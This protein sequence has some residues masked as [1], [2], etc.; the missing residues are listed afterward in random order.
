MPPHLSLLIAVA[1]CAAATAL[2]APSQPLRVCN[3]GGEGCCSCGAG[4]ATLAALQF[5]TPLDGP[6]AVGSSCLARCD[7][8]VAVKRP[9]GEVVVD[10]NGPKA[11]ADLLRGMGYTIDRRLTYAY[12]AASRADELVEESRDREALNAYKRAFSLAIAAG[13]GISWGSP[14]GVERFDDDTRFVLEPGT[15]YVKGQPRGSGGSARSVRAAKAATP[16]QLRWLARTMTSRSRVYSRIANPTASAPVATRRKATRRAI[17]D[18]KYAVALA[19]R[20][21]QM[22]EGAGAEAGLLSDEDAAMATA[23]AVANVGGVAVEDAEGP[24]AQPPAD[25]AVGFGVDPVLTE[26]WER[27]AESY[28]GSRDIEGAITAYEALLRLEPPNAPGLAPPVAAKRGVQELVLLSHRRGIEDTQSLTEG[29][30]RAGESTRSSMTARAISDVEALRKTVERDLD[31]LEA[32]ARRVVNA[33]GSAVR[34]ADA[35]RPPGSAAA[36]PGGGG[37]LERQLA[38]RTLEDLQVVRKIARSDINRL[39]LTLLRGDPL[40]ALFRDVRDGK[41]VWRP[42]SWLRSRGWQ[43]ARGA[44]RLRKARGLDVKEGL[45]DVPAESEIGMQLREQFERGVL[46]QDPLLIQVLLEQ[47]K[48]DPQLVSR[49]V[50][51]AKDRRTGQEIDER[52]R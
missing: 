44:Q 27:L 36:A 5:L 30:Q 20:S 22:E 12:A 16:T 23:A 49:L 19:E 7:R 11:C 13:L 50:A 8:G 26:A 31:T 32:N 46:P 29:L 40:L 34:P 35:E 9:S 42:L 6:Q 41:V 15:R 17:E 4:D 45:R 3:V 37:F 43:G 51:E 14:P 1:C 33:T 47:A 39:E 28:E 48:T 38:M 25:G 24:V 18:A 10:V 52:A 21:L 2:Q